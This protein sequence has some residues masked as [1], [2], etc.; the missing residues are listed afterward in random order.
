MSWSFSQT[1][2][3]RLNDMI[4]LLQICISFPQKKNSVHPCF[5]LKSEWPRPVERRHWFKDR[6]SLSLCIPPT[7][8]S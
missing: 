3:V 2:N 7:D 1:L 8:C 6:A 4:N 5:L